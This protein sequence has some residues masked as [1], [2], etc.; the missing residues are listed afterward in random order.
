MDNRL[1]LVKC[2]TLLYRESLI[3]DKATNSADLVR[4]V[5]EGIKLPD[6]SLSINHEREMLMGLKDTAIWMCGQVADSQIDK[7]DLLQRLKMNCGNDDK[8]YEVLVSGIDRDMDEGS[9]K[10]TVITIY[11]FINDSFR[12]NEIVDK[13]TKAATRLRFD[14]DKIKDIRLFVR[15]LNVEL[16]PY[17]IEATGKD[18]AVVG[19]VDLGDESSLSEVYQEVQDVQEATTLF[20]T[21]WRGLNRTLQGGFRRGEF[22]TLGALPHQYKTGS[23]LSLFKQFA[24]YN[25]P[26]L[27]TPGKKPLLLRI[28]FEDSLLTNLQFLYQNIWENEHNGQTPDLKGLKAAD[29]A[30]YVK[31]RMEAT[32]FHVKMMRVNPSDWTYKDIQSQ[33]LKYEAE[34]YEVQVLML[35]YLPMIPTTGCEQGPAGHADRD[36]VRRMRN[37]CSAKKI[38]CITPW[39]LSTDAK[40]RIREGRTD[41]V[42]GCPGMGFYAG[43]K[44]IDQEVDGELFIHI[45]KLNGAA[46][47]TWQRGKHRWPGILPDIDKYFVLPFPEKGSIQDDMNK[48]GEITLRKIGGGPIGSGSEIP[49]HEFDI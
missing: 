39:Q 11:K 49:F 36:M 22:W 42:K 5:L 2:V 6:L 41:F 3:A 15:D 33:V 38:L 44:Q 20:K 23:T 35:D 32:G 45:E 10:R 21:G 12:E 29:M 26:V 30:A 7:G 16:E 14:R 47:L 13:I 24:M 9:L 18:P 1:L 34:G 31:S 28:S 17:Q 37:F 4:T 25:S 43:S 27:I 46:F 19:Y 48:E 8:L 40:M